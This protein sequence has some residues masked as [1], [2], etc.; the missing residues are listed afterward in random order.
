MGDIPAG[1][2]K[3]ASDILT[4]IINLSLRNGYFP[5]FLKAAEVSPIFKKN[6]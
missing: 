4:E 5:D 2:L 6:P 1:M 3:S